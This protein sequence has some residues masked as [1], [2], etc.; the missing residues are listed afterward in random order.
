MNLY[1]FAGGDPVNFSDPFGLCVYGFRW[2]CNSLITSGD[3]MHA[4]NHATRAMLSGSNGVYDAFVLATIAQVRGD[5]SDFVG[6]QEGM[7]GNQKNAL[8]H[9]YGS[10]QLTRNLG[11]REATE[12]TNAH[13]HKIRDHG[14]ADNKDTAVDLANNR[15]GRSMASSPAN[16]GTSCNALAIQ[17]LPNAAMP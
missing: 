9:L 8:R 11:S 10:C 1:G 5:A 17:A 15:T 2:L 14:D 7:N 3:V 12:V 4:A 16:S 6:A 13:E